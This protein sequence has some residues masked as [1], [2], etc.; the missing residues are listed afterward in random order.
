MWRIWMCEV[1]VEKLSLHLAFLATLFVAT[2]GFSQAQERD[3][4]RL[5][6]Q[7]EISQ[8]A[9][10]NHQ[11]VE[12]E[13]TVVYKQ[14]V[15]TFSGEEKKL[16]VASQRAWVTYKESS[17]KFDGYGTRGGSMNGMV[18]SMC[19]ERLARERIRFISGKLSN[20]SS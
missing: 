15:S 16:F 13:L 9:Y 14:A 3:C 4:S 1:A 17:C 5:S 19:Y 7:T 11:R 8:C 10:W 2:I 20:W 18:I 6:T 12:A